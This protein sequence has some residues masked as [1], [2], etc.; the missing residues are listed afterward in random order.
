MTK[1]DYIIEVNHVSKQFEDGKFAL[2]DV[3]LKIKKGEFVTILGPSGCGKTTLLRCIA[4]FQVPTSG[5][6]FLNGQAVTDMPPYE[7]PVNTV[8]Q[9]YALFPHLNVFDNVGFG[10]KLKKVDQ[11]TIE[12]KVRLSLKTVGM[13][14][15]EYR[16]VDSLSGGQQQ[17][18]A[19][20]RAIINQPKVLL[21][22]EPLAALDL[23]MRK[24][25]QMELREMHKQLGITF[26]YVTH[27]QEEALTLSDRIVVMREGKIQQIGTP[28]DIYNEPENC[29]VADFIGESNLMDATMVHDKLVNFCGVDFPC[30]D[31][32][33]GENQPVDVVV[34]PE[35][36]YISNTPIMPNNPS[37]ATLTNDAWQLHGIIQ[38]CIFKGVHYE[39][40]VLTD[41]DGRHGKYELMIQNYHA[42]LPGEHVGLLVKP[43]DI[44]VMHKER[45]NNT[46]E[47]TVCNGNKVKFIGSEWD[48]TAEVATAFNVGDAVNV[49][50]DFSDISLLDDENDGNQS[51]EVYFILYKGDHYHLQI[52]PDEGEDLYVD[53]KD[54]W[55]DGDRVGIRIAPEAIHLTKKQADGDVK[56]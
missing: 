31:T 37:A 50:L 28:I 19:I 9:K 51:G 1:S 26:V 20:A 21:L 8:F 2:D 5:E 34:R 43:E 44:Q 35:D 12:K 32:G 33:F 15:Y 38:S 25:M 45:F 24:D 29:F 52:R 13:T 27:D 3:S 10:L 49:E 46:L 17:R 39:M 23:K 22:D 53:T 55:D 18:V 42:Y 7:R 56:A 47:G 30:V 16:D 36:L 54:V 11:A 48:V 40:T 41:H 4:G 14:D 6:I